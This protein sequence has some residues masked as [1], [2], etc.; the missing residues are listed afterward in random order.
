VREDL[1][2]YATEDYAYEESE[3]QKAT[4]SSLQEHF[5]TLVPYGYENDGGR[6]AM[7]S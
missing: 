7:C 1:K 3:V 2:C 5:E 4:L 6:S